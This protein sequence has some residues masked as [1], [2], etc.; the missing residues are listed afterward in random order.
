[1]TSYRLTFV[2]PLISRGCY[3]NR[4]EIRP[5]SVR[6]QLRWWFR[7]LGGSYRDEKELFG[8]IHGKPVA[9]SRI[10]LRVGGMEGGTGS[11]PSL[12][13]KRGMAASSKAAFLAGAAF[14]LH[15]LMRR[16]PSSYGAMIQSFE[17]AMH[18]WLLAG[19]LGLRSTRGAGSFVWKAVRGTGAGMPADLESYKRQLRVV[20]GPPSLATNAGLCAWILGRSFSDPEDARRCISDT[21]GGKDDKSGASDLARIGFPL[22]RVFGGRKTS[23]LRFRIVQLAE[24]FYIVAV[25]DNRGNVTGNKPQDLHSAIDLLKRKDKEIGY[26]LGSE[27]C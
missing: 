12:P 17:K 20:I 9:S 10:V 25:W 21:V 8:G 15:V 14:D 24:E 7:G 4:P 18:A 22:G 13:H 2:T 11:V 19:S 26:I 6:G 3:E 16:M 27:I 5:S 1:M 23:P